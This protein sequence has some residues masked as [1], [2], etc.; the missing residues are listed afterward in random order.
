MENINEGDKTKISFLSQICPR[1]PVG[2][3]G[4]SQEE[5]EKEEEER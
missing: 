1:K 3:E 5:E 2:G 4:E